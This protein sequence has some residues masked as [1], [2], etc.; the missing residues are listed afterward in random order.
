MY[1]RKYQLVLGAVAVAAAAVTLTVLSLGTTASAAAGPGQDFSAWPGNT[2]SFQG[3]DWSCEF[4]GAQPKIVV[5][6]R[7]GNPSIGIALTPN[8]LRVFR[9]DRHA[10]TLLYQRGRNP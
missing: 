7:T 10:K 9:F 2:V 3:L 8:D 5:C 4:P 1:L 6:R